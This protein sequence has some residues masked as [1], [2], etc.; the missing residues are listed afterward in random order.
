MLSEEQNRFMLFLLK[1]NISTFETQS[2]FKN[3]RSFYISLKTLIRKGFI[4]K[5]L[6]VKP[7]TYYLTIRGKKYLSWYNEFS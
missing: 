2:I 3:K 6:F 7:N 5:K 1:N 4:S